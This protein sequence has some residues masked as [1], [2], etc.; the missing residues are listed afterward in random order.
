M[1]RD[2]LR[3]LL[4]KVE[5]GETPSNSLIIRALSKKVTY[6]LGL[7]LPTLVK[8][9]LN[10]GDIRGMGAAKA[11]HDALLPGWLWH[12]TSSGTVILDP[13]Q[14]GHA[15]HVPGGRYDPARAWLIAILKALIAE[16]E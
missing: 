7:P 1:D 12:V 16:G 15:I 8:C 2:A 11:L 13:P 6:D 4:A 14:E 10:P 3:E 9:I 5:E